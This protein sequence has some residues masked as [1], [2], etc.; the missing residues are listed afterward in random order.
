LALF[1]GFGA[2]LLEKTTEKYDLS[3][4]VGMCS[5]GSAFPAGMGQKLIKKFHLKHFIE[6]KTFHLK[7]KIVYLSKY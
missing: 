6:C 2:A 4:L 3:S 1:P 7:S 5:G